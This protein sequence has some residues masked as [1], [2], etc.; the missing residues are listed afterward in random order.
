VNDYLQDIPDFQAFI[1]RM[2][3]DEK[4]LNHVLQWDHFR[5]Q[6]DFIAINDKYCIDLLGR[7]ENLEQFTE[8][9]CELI[10]EPYKELKKINSSSRDDYK[11]Y[12][13]NE[14][15]DF[16]YEIYHKEINF[17]GYEY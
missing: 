15:I 2:M 5:P 12:Y 16:V 3:S 9:F 17:L 8:K 10:D 1:S 6:W 13:T 14:M 4:F 11:S 7:Y